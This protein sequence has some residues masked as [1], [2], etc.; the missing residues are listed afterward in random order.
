V[1]GHS[2]LATLASLVLVIAVAG[3]ERAVRSP[4]A[5]GGSVVPGGGS[6]I[7]ASFSPKPV[8]GASPVAAG[9]VVATIGLRD[10]RPWRIAWGEDRLW[11]LGRRGDD[12]VVLAID[13]QTNQI[14][15]QP[16]EL[17]THGWEIAAGEGG[18]W[19][20]SDSD[21]S[22]TRIDP[23]RMAP[24]V[25]IGGPSNAVGPALAVGFGFIWT[26]DSDTR[27][28]GQGE[29]VSQ[30]DPRTNKIT[31]QVAVGLS[32]QAIAAADGYVWVSNHDDGT[33][34][35]IEA[36]TLSTKTEP[37]IGRPGVAVGAHGAAAGFGFVGF[38]GTHEGLVIPVDPSTALSQSPFDP[39][40]VPQGMVLS[41][42]RLWVGPSVFDGNDERRI[43]AWDVSPLRSAGEV[44]V[45]GH[46][47]FGLA[48]G[49]GSIWAGIAG[50]IVRIEPSG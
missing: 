47:C 23:H 17:T 11:V 38:A 27:A 3:C 42:G 33:A 13:P 18:V 26:G 50:G 8:G 14:S 36:S 9:V 22:V 37:L 30:I 16:I 19:V 4:R 2:I 28:A 12:S 31:H 21:A 29:T 7:S 24:N 20:A 43:V 40:V 34:T 46:C 35:R 49:D 32:P 5:A 6:A 25:V 15:G 41:A 39:G 48:A 45:G 44:Q 1:T 10:V